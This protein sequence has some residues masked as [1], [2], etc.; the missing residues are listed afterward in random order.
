MPAV[1]RKT[2]SLLALSAALL[3]GADPKPSGALDIV[4]SG[5]YSEPAGFHASARILDWNI[6]R[7]KHLEGIRALMRGLQPDLCVFQEVDLGARRTHERDIARQLAQD[8][9]MN[10][11]FAPEFRELGQST[12]DGAAY[13]GQA[14][15]SK[16][17]IR[18]SR[19]LRFE[20]QSG[21]WK[22]QPFLLSSLAIM[23]RREGGRIAQVSELENGDGMIVVYNLH[24]ESRA[25]EATRLAQLDEAL[26]DAA[27]YP[28][29]TPLIIAGD[30]NTM[31]RHSPLVD[32][33]RAA[34]Y[35]SAF[36]GKRQRTH[37]LIG[38]LDW[39]FV[40]GA[41]QLH[42]AS[43]IRDAHASDH[44]PIFVDARF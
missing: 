22:P 43:V 27:R 36:G 7:G 16:L 26:A 4:H 3:D 6:D 1:I 20:R 14:I 24:L 5:A 10:F 37:L 44:F 28:A 42:D 8:F 19:I 30:F 40:R 15:L 18:S 38:A 9:K 2:C 11:A 13:Q 23:Q 25:R 29:E 17:P 35:R 33:L 41:V 31:S 21:F 39:V 12:S 32:R 34:G